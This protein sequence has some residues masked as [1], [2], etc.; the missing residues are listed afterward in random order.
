VVCDLPDL[1]AP[2][3]LTATDR[4][5]QLR[6]LYK[7]YQF[8]TWLNEIDGLERPAAGI[9]AQTIGVA[10]TIRRRRSWRSITKRC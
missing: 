5:P 10:T 2:T 8:R 9:P 3:A 4:I 1:P 6:E 7:R